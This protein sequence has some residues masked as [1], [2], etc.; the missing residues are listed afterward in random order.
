[1]QRQR[2]ITIKNVTEKKE[3]KKKR[4]KSLIGFHSV[5][6]IDNYN[7][8]GKKE[9]KIQKNLQNKSKH[10]NNKCFFS[11][12]CQ[13][14]FSCW[15]SQSTLPPQDA[16][17]HCADLWTCCGGSSDSNLVLLCVLASSVHSY[18]NQCIFFCRSS[19]CLFICSIDTES[20]YLIVWI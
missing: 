7:K 9:K 8:G 10:K 4:L 11:H 18:Q 6:K 13:S 17:Q 5:N 20:A 12:C 3:E 16:L 2:F 1:M 14:P 19:Q 15:E